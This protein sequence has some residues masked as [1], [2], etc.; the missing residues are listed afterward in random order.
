MERMAV[1]AHFLRERRRPD[2]VPAVVVGAAALLWQYH[3]GISVSDI[4]ERLGV[5]RQHVH[6]EVAH[7]LGLPPRTLARLLR[8][9]AATEAIRRGTG[10]AAVAADCGFY[11]QAHLAREFR[12]LAG[13]TPSGYATSVQAGPALAALASDAEG[14][15]TRPSEPEVSQ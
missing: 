1:V 11:D 5:G 4:A 2:A 15:C 7:H 6:R 13:A 9:R 3:G 8:F 12:T 14:Q 10:L